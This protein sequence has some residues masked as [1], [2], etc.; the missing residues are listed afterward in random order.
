MRTLITTKPDNNKNKFISTKV[1]NY[2]IFIFVI[3]YLSIICVYT[4]DVFSFLK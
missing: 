2:L 4:I 3:V 1:L